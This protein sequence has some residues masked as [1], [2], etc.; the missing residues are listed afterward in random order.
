[1]G[2]WVM[3]GFGILAGVPYLASAGKLMAEGKPVTAAEMNKNVMKK[4]EEPE[5]QREIKG[6][7][8]ASDGTIYGGGKMGL[9]ALKEGNWAAVEGIDAQDVKAVVAGAGD[10]LFV[11]HHDGVAMRKDGTWSEIHEGEVHNIALGS[12]GHI[13]L[14]TKKPTSLLQHQADGSWKKL[15]DGL[16][17]AE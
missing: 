5:K 6:L 4:S 16:P 7:S 15:N 11:A 13:L 10:V 8:V 9:Y 2:V 17:I 14:A 3:I 12:D 1:M